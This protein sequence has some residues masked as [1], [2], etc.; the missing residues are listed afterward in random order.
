V[1]DDPHARGGPPTYVQDGAVSPS[2]AERARTLVAANG[3]G[4]LSTVALEP[5][6]YPFGSIVTY[7]LDGSGAPLILMSTMAE[8]ARNLE[9]DPRASLL[10]AAA[11]EGAGR[12]A[13]AR[14][15]LVGDVQRVPDDEQ[16]TAT[17]AYLAGHPGAFWA[18]F[19]DFSVHR[20][21]VRA[22]RYV[23]G[24][25]EMSW[26]DPVAYAAATPDPVAPGEADIV[27]HVNADHR[28]ALRTI[29]G[30]FLDVPDPVEDVT[31]I[32]C[33]R[34]GFEVR[35]TTAPSE[36]GG[37]AGLA[38]GRLAFDQV[39]DQPSATRGAMVRAVRAAEAGRPR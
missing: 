27:A 15:T 8:H 12:L 9:G 39:L 10:V 22:I 25:G 35:L 16:E 36:P 1:S 21:D 37:D 29:V 13:V 38:F 26:V 4:T 5:T 30:A 24:F 7:A 32:S 14:A 31:M 33:D 19:P 6:G 18:R 34:Y 11:G 20:L 2:A 17:A 3:D 23:R 28:D